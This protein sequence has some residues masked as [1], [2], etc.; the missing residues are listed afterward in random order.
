MPDKL[1][2]E[3]RSANMRAVQGKNTAP[4]MFVRRMVHGMGYRYRLHGRDLPGSPDLVF[5]S[6]R[7]AIFVHGCFWH[8]H[9]G[10]PRANAPK[11]NI[12]FWRTKLDRNAARDAEQKAALQVQGWRVLVIWECQTK[13]ETALK[14]LLKSFLES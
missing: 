5:R 14:N 1:S 4:E 10:C 11:S 13:D 12:D 3:R 8:Q 9:K 2:R 6:R 7:K